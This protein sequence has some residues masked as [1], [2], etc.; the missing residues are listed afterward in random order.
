MTLPVFTYEMIEGYAIGFGIIGILI[1]V[2]IYRNR[3]K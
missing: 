2:G 3:R 1:A